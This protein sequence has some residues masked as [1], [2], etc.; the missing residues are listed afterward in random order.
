MTVGDVS[1]YLGQFD[2]GTPVDADF[3]D[4]MLA[5]FAEHRN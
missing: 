5:Q 2:P 3:F 1:D 4:T